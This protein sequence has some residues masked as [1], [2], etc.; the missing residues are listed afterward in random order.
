MTSSC[1]F[2]AA[3]A[4]G[5][6]MP[7]YAEPVPRPCPRNAA[8]RPGAIRAQPGRAAPQRSAI[9]HAIQLKAAQSVAAVPAGKTQSGPGLPAPL[10]AGIEQLSGI[11]MDGVR[12]HRDSPEPAKV[13]A[14]AYARGSDIHLGPGQEQHLPHEAWHVV[15]QAQGR[16]KATTQLKDGV[17]VNDDAGLEE[18]ADA[19]GAKALLL[20]G[21][22]REAAAIP[23]QRSAANS[24]FS[25]AGNPILQGM[26]L[27]VDGKELEEGLLERAHG[28]PL[29]TLLDLGTSAG[30]PAAI[31]LAAR[32]AAAAKANQSEAQEQVVTWLS[33][34]LHEKNFRIDELLNGSLQR[35]AA[36]AEPMDEGYGHP[37][38]QSEAEAGEA[39]EKDM[40]AGDHA[41]DD[42]GDVAEQPLKPGDLV[43]PNIEA[44]HQEALATALKAQK[45]DLYQK[46]IDLANI[47]KV[48]PSL[49]IFLHWYNAGVL[50]RSQVTNLL[51]AQLKR[52]AGDSYQAIYQTSN[53]G[54]FKEV[55]YT[56]DGQGCI[57]FRHNSKSTP[58]TMWKNPVEVTSEVQLNKG[59]STAGFGLGT[60]GLIPLANA[61][62]AQHFCIANRMVKNG[63]GSGSPPGYTWHHLPAKYKMVLVDRNVH[64]K[65]GHNGGK[66]LWT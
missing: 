13:G 22:R 45:P 14:L 9:W 43:L 19:M 34:T 27:N 23:V 26:W 60:K 39:A 52:K 33:E 58:K 17:P 57:N 5:G 29:G 3:P 59:S 65:H 40:V 8:S 15:Q 28:D 32:W 36:A 48:K 11:A 35:L 42:G 51:F 54:I 62:R 38:E 24:A 6:A 46:F 18:E 41:E 16:V 12:V 4:E 21:P 49:L 7:R 66:L 44:L 63:A 31:E 50:T 37:V 2:A 1:A 61:S 53:F 64:G 30:R 20:A 25:K 10:K 56:R 47:R 55:T